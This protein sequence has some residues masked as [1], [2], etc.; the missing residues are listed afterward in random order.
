VNALHDNGIL[1]R[2]ARAG[3]RH[4]YYRLRAHAWE[5]VLEAR[6]RTIGE[7]RRAADRSLR[8]SH[9]A[10]DQRLRDLRDMCARVEL[11]L[12]EILHR[13]ASAGAPQA[14]RVWKTGFTPFGQDS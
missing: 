9:G 4:V 11:G 14:K 12:A 2:V 6:F 5:N 8:A 3:D 10:A 7:V 13:G 1:E